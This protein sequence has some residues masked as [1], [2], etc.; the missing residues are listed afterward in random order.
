M[1]SNQDS[2][3]FRRRSWPR[4]LGAKW[5]RLYDWARVWLFRPQ[6]LPWDHWLLIRHSRKDPEDCA[7][8]VI[9]IRTE[10]TLAAK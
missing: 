7:Y 4:G 2:R 6:E 8:Y 9:F 5:P 10:M 3:D 1:T